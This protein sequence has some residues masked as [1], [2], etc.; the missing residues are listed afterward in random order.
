MVFLSRRG[1]W[2]DISKR[3]KERSDDLDEVK[4]TWSLENKTPESTRR[5]GIKN[6]GRKGYDMM[7]FVGVARVCAPV[8]TPMVL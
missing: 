8:Y 3:A 6:K 7:F 5:G 1:V 2:V 4:L